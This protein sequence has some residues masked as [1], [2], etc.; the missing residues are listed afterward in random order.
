MP[1]PSTSRSRASR[2][3]RSSAWPMKASCRRRRP[4]CR[5]STRG[6]PSSCPRRPSMASSLR[7]ATA[8]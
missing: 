6:R 5:A 3:A 2:N 1:P 7:A 4:R 8:W